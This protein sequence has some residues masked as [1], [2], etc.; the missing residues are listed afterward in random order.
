MT[1]N[2]NLTEA[3]GDGYI[4]A[5]SKDRK[6]MVDELV[7]KM[8]ELHSSQSTTSTFSDPRDD[9][10]YKT[11]KIGNQVWMAENLAFKPSSGNYWAYDNN[12]NNVEKYGYLYDWQTALNACPAGWHL[13]TDAEWTTLTDYVGGSMD[14][15]KIK[16]TSGW[17]S[18]GNGTDEYGFSALPGGY[19]SDDGTIYNVGYYGCWWSSTETHP[20]YRAWNRLMHYFNNQVFRLYYNKAWG[21]SV[22]CIKD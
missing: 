8:I 20:A 16:A 1:K 6:Q 15:T 10:T 5:L 7:N 2:A 18:G 14:G 22:R 13:P 17:Y 4:F 9:K 21:F 19:R 12:S 3:I 11:V